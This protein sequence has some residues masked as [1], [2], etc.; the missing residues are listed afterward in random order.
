[1]GFS[2][3]LLVCLV[4]FFRAALYHHFWFFFA[5]EILA[6][7]VRNND[8]IKRVQVGNMEKKKINMLA[9]DTACFLHGD[10]GSFQAI[11]NTLDKFAYFSE[12]KVNLSK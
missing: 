9:D 11:F 7:A 8:D 4:D 6:I 10:L 5:I 12:C 1:M 3:A 2:V